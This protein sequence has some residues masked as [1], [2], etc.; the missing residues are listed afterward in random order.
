MIISRVFITYVTGEL[1]MSLPSSEFTGP[2]SHDALFH[3]TRT[4]L[5]G[6][7]P[8]LAHAA[9]R[10]QFPPSYVVVGVYRLFTDKALYIPAWEKCK[11]GTQRGIVVAL[12]WV[13]PP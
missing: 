13:R 11:H 8:T 4:G 6:T 7:P 9:Q 12:A 2:E 5:D 3:Q 10:L 1:A